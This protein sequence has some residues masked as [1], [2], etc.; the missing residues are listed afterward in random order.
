MLGT[1]GSLHEV[2][3]V[4]RLLHRDVPHCGFEIEAKSNNC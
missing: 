2:M 4:V 3:R 1:D